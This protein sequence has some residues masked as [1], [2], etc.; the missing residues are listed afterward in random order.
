[1]GHELDSLRE[2]TRIIASLALK[3]KICAYINEAKEDPNVK[4]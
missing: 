2:H 3:T 4:L 1:M